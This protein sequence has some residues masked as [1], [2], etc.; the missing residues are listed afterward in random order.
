LLRLLSNTHEVVG[1]ARSVPPEN[2]SEIARWQQVD[3]LDRERV[4][5]AVR[6]LRPTAVYHCA[7]LPHVAESW[8][9]TAQPLRSNVLATHHV[10]DALRRADVACRV[11]ITGS[12]AV[13][14]PSL[15]PLTEDDL[16]TASSPYALSKLAQEQLGLRAVTEDGLGVIVTRSF[17]HTGARQT[18]AFVA[19]SIARQIALIERGSQDPVIR[20]GNLDTQRDLSDVRDVVRAY[21]G[22]MKSGTP[23]TVYNVASGVG[24]TIGAILDTLLARAR[25]PVRIETDPAR[26]RPHDALA[27]IGNPT[28][29]KEAT[30]WRPTISFDQMLDD[31]LDYWRRRTRG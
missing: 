26:L 29:L 7:G 10:L 12:A 4:R 3:L 8:S 11:L 6:D 22:L 17:N 27:L 31:L 24:H 30:G 28:R 25:V 18:P 14:A 20:V 15:Q 21:S 2:L 19:P 5:A 9:D 13:Y 16:V 23:G 1:W